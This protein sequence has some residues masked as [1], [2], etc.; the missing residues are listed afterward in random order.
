LLPEVSQQIRQLTGRLPGP[1]LAPASRCRR[2][3]H[4]E[5]G[6]TMPTAAY[7]RS[8]RSKA[9]RYIRSTRQPP[10]P[11]VPGSPLP[12]RRPAQRLRHVAGLLPRTGKMNLRSARPQA[13]FSSRFPCAQRAHG[14]PKLRRHQ[15]ADSHSP[16]DFGSSPIQK[17]RGRFPG[18]GSTVLAMLNMYR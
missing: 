18:A 9:P 6:M 2:V 5:P 1:P 10:R 11:Q 17:A 12:K 7:P 3:L 15:G 14:T 8:A 4:V 13:V 16:L